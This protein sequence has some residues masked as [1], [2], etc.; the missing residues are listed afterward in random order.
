MEEALKREELELELNQE[1]FVEFLSG[2]YLFDALFDGDNEGK[3]LLLLG[4]EMKDYYA[5]YEEQMIACCNEIFQIGQ[6]QYKLRKEE[7]KEYCNCVEEAKRQNQEENIVRNT[8]IIKIRRTIYFNFPFYHVKTYMEQFMFDKNSKVL[9]Y[10]KKYQRDVE[11]NHI[12]V[13]DYHEL[14]RDLSK[15]FEELVHIH[16]K[17]LMEIE[18][19]LYVQMDDCNQSFERSMNEMI[20]TFIEAAQAIF[21]QI[22]T[23]EQTYIENITEFS[24][25]I[26]TLTTLQGDSNW[27]EEVAWVRFIE[28]PTPLKYT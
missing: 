11:R 24:G 20:N 7:I 8:L 3:A 17:R 19:Q 2:R 23:L 12:S 18:M 1:S 27:P 9:I 21:T 22:R 14:I 5:E 10:L 15:K 4:E 16:W 13:D 26:L 6:D 28:R 25:R